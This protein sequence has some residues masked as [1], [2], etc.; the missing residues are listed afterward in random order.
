MST[1]RILV[2]GIGNLFMG[3]DAFGIEVVNGLRERPLP[4]GVDAI[5]FGIRGIDLTYA[6]LDGYDRVILVDAVQRGGEP[7]TLYVIEPE[8]PEAAGL[9]THEMTP[10]KVLA[11]AR[12]LGG[13]PQNVLIVGCEPAAFGS[14]DE[15]QS[16][17]SGAV[18]AAVGE[19]VLLIESILAG[20]ELPAASR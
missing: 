10:A 11:A 4:A 3:D 7:G 8:S 12:A 15:P 5:D 20:Q 16:G 2:A 17:L 14:E 1:K 9:D 6:L 13:A 19:A 18:R